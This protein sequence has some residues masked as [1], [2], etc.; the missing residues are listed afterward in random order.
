MVMGI[1]PGS[2][3]CGYGIIKTNG[4]VSDYIASGEIRLNPKSPLHIRLKLLHEG[5][6]SI[7]KQYKPSEAVVEKIFFAKSVRSALSLGHARAIALLSASS[8]GVSVYEYSALEVKKTVTG[9]GRAEKAQVEA[10][11]RRIL[12]IDTPLSSDSADALAL[13]LCRTS[14]AKLDALTLKEVR[15]AR[16]R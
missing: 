3:S 5:L 4:T 13:A 10:M 11:V 7:I 8:E 12:N 14:R 1:D 15:K 2:L 16:L 9:Y 6:L